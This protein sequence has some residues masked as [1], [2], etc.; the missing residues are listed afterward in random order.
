MKLLSPLSYLRVS[1]IR[2]LS[3]EDSTVFLVGNKRDLTDNR[4]ITSEQ[5]M[6]LAQSLGVS[7]LETS[8][9]DDTN[10]KQTFEGLVDAIYKKNPN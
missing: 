9:K 8:A 2:D 1:Q 7:Y 3:L 10:L 4:V 6:D 5:A